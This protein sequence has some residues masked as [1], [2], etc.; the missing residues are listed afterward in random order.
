M[1]ERFEPVLMSCLGI[2]KLVLGR[3]WKIHLWWWYW[4]WYLWWKMLLKEV[5]LWWYLWWWYSWW[6]KLL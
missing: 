2:V 4:W 3:W 5:M 6:W 1:V